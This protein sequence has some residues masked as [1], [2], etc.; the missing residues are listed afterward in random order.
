MKITMKKKLFLVAML[1]ANVLSFAQKRTVDYLNNSMEKKLDNFVPTGWSLYNASILKCLSNNDL[2]ETYMLSSGGDSLALINVETDHLG[3]SHF[4]YQQFHR[5]ILVDDAIL[6]IHVSPDSIVSLYSNIVVF[7]DNDSIFVPQ[8]TLHDSECPFLS[9]NDKLLITR[10]NDDGGF[11]DTNL[12]LSYMRINAEGDE[13]FYDYHTNEIIK[14]RVTTYYSG[15]NTPITINTLFNGPQTIQ[16]TYRIPYLIGHHYYYLEDHERWNGIFAFGGDVESSNFGPEYY[17]ESNIIRQRYINDF[18]NGRYRDA[19]SA[20]WAME[21][22]YDFYALCMGRLSYDNNCAPIRMFPWSSPYDG[23]RWISSEKIFT[24]GAPHLLAHHAVA[25]LDA[26]GHEFTH[27]VISSTSGLSSGTE[28]RT[29]NE[30]FSDIF[31]T[32]VE[33]FVEGDNGDYYI[34][35]DFWISDGKLRDMRNPKSKS[36][37]DTYRGEFWTDSVDVVH[38]NAG[39]QNKWFYL[40]S[41]GGVGINDNGYAYHVSGIGH[42]KAAQ[43]AYRNMVYYLSSSSTFSDAKNG[44]IMSAID[45]FGVQSNEVLQTIL[46]WD[47]VGVSSVYGIHYNLDVSQYC[48]LFSD[49]HDAGQIVSVKCVGE[50]RSNCAFSSN[51]IPVIFAAGGKIVLEDGFVS[52]DNFRATPI[53][54]VVP[55]MINPNAGSMVHPPEQTIII[56]NNDVTSITDNNFSVSPNPVSS[57][58]TLQSQEEIIYVACYNA[59][60]LIVLEKQLVGN[61]KSLK[62]NIEDKPAGVYFVKAVLRSGQVVN[63][64]II[65]K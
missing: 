37:P 50:L 62:I 14:T 36:H 15:Q 55:R 39:V 18:N 4:S 24:F 41:E 20:F 3:F 32:M 63:K 45:L 26:V 34:G 65:K 11:A 13:V 19:A 9:S 23:A 8:K 29:L 25:S 54:S 47:A 42:D 43:I 1:F 64:K 17:E 44:A 61:E 38:T 5:G 28:A 6:K 22:T 2:S 27:A 53:S 46:A 56:E 52:G 51:N 16:T 10:I 21:K 31:G 35:E 12:V 40:L 59:D 57:F 7:N 60:G 33:F 48:Q 58:F 49:M 30:S